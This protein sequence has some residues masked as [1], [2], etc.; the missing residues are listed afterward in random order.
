MRNL[1]KCDGE[2]PN[3]GVNL[4][5]FFVVIVSTERNILLLMKNITVTLNMT[6][7]LTKNGNVLE[8]IK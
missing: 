6:V 5:P 4:S 7:L 3:S 8:N 1:I 2:T